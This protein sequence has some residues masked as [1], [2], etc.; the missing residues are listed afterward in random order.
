MRKVGEIPTRF[1]TSKRVH[2]RW[3]VDSRT[4]TVNR[5]QNSR[6]YRCSATVALFE[7]SALRRRLSFCAQDHRES[8][9]Q[10]TGGQVEGTLLWRLHSVS[11]VSLSYL[12]GHRSTTDHA[13]TGHERPTANRPSL[14]PSTNIPS[15][16]DF[17]LLQMSFQPQQRRT[18]PVL[19]MS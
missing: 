11:L 12:R 13:T 14:W 8:V 5:L 4:I 17:I 10:N 7:W 18:A 2:S 19:A 15:S 9:R 3:P 6:A 1:F 16:T